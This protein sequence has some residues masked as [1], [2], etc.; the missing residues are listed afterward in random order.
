[1]AIGGV[2]LLAILVFGAVGLAAT[3]LYVDDDYTS[4]TPGWGTTHFNT[5]QAAI[6]AASAGDT[7]NVA[8]GTYTE[9]GQIVINKNLTIVGADKA[10]TIIKPSENTGDSSDG[11]AW[12]LVNQGIIFNLS[13][14]TL[15]GTGKMIY[16]GIRHKGTGTIQ[17]VYF[18]GIT[19][20]DYYGYAIF[21]FGMCGA[22]DVSDCAFDNI[23]REGINY[24]G[25]GTTGT[26]ADNTYTGNGPGDYLEYGVEVSTGA[27]VTI[28]GSTITNCAGNDSPWA[29][30]GIVV[31]GTGSKAT[32]T[33]NTVTGNYWGIAVGTEAGTA[34]PEAHAHF[35]NIT[36]NYNLGARHGS[37]YGV[38]DAT[39]NW[40]G[41]DSGP[42]HATLNSAGL[43]NTVS[44]NVDFD[45]WTGMSIECVVTE[46][47]QVQG[48]TVIN[49]CAQTSVEIETAGGT[50]DV[51]IA[52]YTSPPPDTPSFGAGATYVDVQLSDP[53]VVTELT[54]TFDGMAADT[55]IYFY[56]PGTGW[57]ACSNQTTRRERLL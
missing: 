2:L 30:A 17:N 19:Y 50:T 23:G 43:G 14:V 55:V 44:D 39:D 53:G 37:A 25:A 21:A 27:V 54:I 42:Y 20:D 13:Q 3:T 1:V 41:D 52:R 5:I 11:R 28:T 4:G 10:T 16:H 48:D 29:S 9:V 26:Y 47:G 35:N 6:Y 18:T 36:G 12:W 57:I 15:D 46:P 8:A 45:P 56:L 34:T 31:V 22:V 24:Y 32:I 49:S 38:F 7:V 40:W 51:T 33:G